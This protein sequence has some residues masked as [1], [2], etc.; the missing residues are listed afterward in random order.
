[1]S[2]K[3]AQAQILGRKAPPAGYKDKD[4]LGLP[5]R[6]AFALQEDGW[7]LRSAIPWV[8]GVDWLDAE[9]AAR[10]R[11]RQALDAVRH[12]AVSSLFGLSGELA[13]TLHQAEKALD[14]LLMS[15][16]TMPESCVDR[17]TSS[18][19]MLF[20]FSQK[21]RYYFDRHAI[22]VPQVKGTRERMKAG[23]LDRYANGAVDAKGYRGPVG[24]KSGMSYCPAGRNARNVWMLPWRIPNEPQG[25]FV[26]DDGT[27]VA[28]FAAY[29]Q[30]LA[31]RAIRAST[32]EAG[33]CCQC[34]APFERV[35]RP[36]AEYAAHLG[37]DWADYDQDQVEGRGHFDGAQQRPVKRNAPAL[38]A[39]YLTIGWVPTCTCHGEPVERLIDCPKCRG[40]GQELKYPRGNEPH[41]AE[42][43][44]RGSGWHELKRDHDGPESAPP[45]PTGVPCPTCD[46][47]GQVHGEIWPDDVLETWPRKPCVAGDMFA[48][49]GTTGRGALALGRSTVL[50]DLHPDYVR[51]ISERLHAFPDDVEQVR[52]SGNDDE[53]EAE[54]EH[55]PQLSFAIGGDD[56]NTE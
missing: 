40:T 51:L 34:N 14:R 3:T 54:L 1:M 27:Q 35:T 53:P 37:K 20:L 2:T 48:G 13:R 6:L 29:P 32:S 19:E 38:T 4:L 30:A 16:S 9:R 28:H 24:G 8:K 10:D 42:P 31:E 56:A 12:E 50:I 17:P 52:G 26:L 44:P 18:Y 46:G 5:W 11:I 45:Q 23:F 15:G 39:E 33:C 55:S 21:P 25:T 36:T 7:Y 49:S 43:V 47:T 41:R 22:K